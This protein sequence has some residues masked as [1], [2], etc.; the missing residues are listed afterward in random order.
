MYH[1]GDGPPR[2]ELG[3][4]KQPVQSVLLG[5]Q[6]SQGPGVHWAQGRG[7]VGQAGWQ[8]HTHLEID[9]LLQEQTV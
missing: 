3:E 7:T 8:S 2:G 6:A 9:Y 1:T 5:G 4:E